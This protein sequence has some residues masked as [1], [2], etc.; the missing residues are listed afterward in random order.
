MT[1]SAPEIFSGGMEILRLGKSIQNPN[2][3]KQGMG[4]QMDL[5]MLV[6]K[7]EDR[8]EDLTNVEAT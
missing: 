1:Y 5:L 4:C 8:S 3:T 2:H 6:R 7:P